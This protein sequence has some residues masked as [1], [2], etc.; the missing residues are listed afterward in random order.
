MMHAR[1]RFDRHIINGEYHASW[2]QLDSRAMDTQFM[3]GRRRRA[4]RKEFFAASN[5]NHFFSLSLSNETHDGFQIIP[6]ASGTPTRALS[7]SKST[8]TQC[9][10]VLPSSK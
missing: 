3:A 2:R 5:V 7:L 4:K 6:F 8:S 1:S 9:T 10:I